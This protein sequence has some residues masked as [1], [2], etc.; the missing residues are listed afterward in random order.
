MYNKIT[1]KGNPE[2]QRKEETHQSREVRTLNE[3]QIKAL[4]EM[5][6]KALKSEIVDR[7]TIT[8]KPNSK[9]KQG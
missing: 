3:E 7:L 9:P 8:I 1:G 4:L 2:E 5:L 6:E